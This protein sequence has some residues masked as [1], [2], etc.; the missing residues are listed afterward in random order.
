[1]TRDEYLEFHQAL[2]E[3]AR[4]LSERKNHDYAGRGGLEPFAN[5]VRC[6]SMGVC[7][8]EKGFLV[9]LTDKMSRLSSFA[10]AGV[11]AVSTE[12][13]RDTCMDVINY[14]ALFLAYIES[15]RENTF[16]NE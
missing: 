9:R 12:S 13:L 6:E 5:F 10:D 3:E 1:M 2:C 4:R 15:R 16:G 11:F 14:T 7:S 8:T